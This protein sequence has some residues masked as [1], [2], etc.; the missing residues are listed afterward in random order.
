MFAVEVIDKLLAVFQVRIV[1]RQMFCVFIV[2]LETDCIS[3]FSIAIFP[4]RYAV[5][6]VLIIITAFWLSSVFDRQSFCM[7]R[8]QGFLTQCL[9]TSSMEN[10]L[11]FPLK[12][13]LFLNTGLDSARS[14]YR[15]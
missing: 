11:V 3:I 6:F 8:Q 10:R 9:R 14:K 12:T 5:D 13:P 2:P 15:A 4:T 7:P 1:P